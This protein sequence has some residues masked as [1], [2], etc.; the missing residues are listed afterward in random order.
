MVNLIGEGGHQRKTRGTLGKN[1]RFGI[2]VLFGGLSFKSN[3][4]KKVDP[5]KYT[6]HAHWGLEGETK[7][8]S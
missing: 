1:S 3:K 6:G 7:T 2:F 8:S 4:K 5:W